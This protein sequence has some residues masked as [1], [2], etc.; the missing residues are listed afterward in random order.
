MLRL[1]AILL[2]T[3][4]AV[5]PLALGRVTARATGLF[6]VLLGL[7]VMAAF[8]ALAV[9]LLAGETLFRE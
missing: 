5:S 4:T 2:V 9:G 7:L 6:R 3:A 1:A 8:A